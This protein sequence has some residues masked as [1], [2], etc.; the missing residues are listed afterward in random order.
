MAKA[1]TQLKDA[2]DKAVSKVAGAR[3]VSATAEMKGGRSVASIELLRGGR[4]QSVTEE[5]D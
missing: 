1:K 4:I 2:V 5:L 3:P